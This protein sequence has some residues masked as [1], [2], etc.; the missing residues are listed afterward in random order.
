MSGGE[1]FSGGQWAEAFCA[2]EEYEFCPIDAYE[3]AG[4]LA[5][6][7]AS[8]REG[9]AENDEGLLYAAITVAGGLVEEFD[10]D[11]LARVIAC[12]DEEGEKGL[13]DRARGYV[14]ARWPDFPVEE[15]AD[16]HRFGAKHALHVH[17]RTV[18]DNAGFTFLFDITPLTERA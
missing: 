11:F 10:R 17:E 7:L 3:H 13:A 16:L 14:I 15:I 5:G 12:R 2:A 1:T 9:E 6:V 18:E 8:L 4:G